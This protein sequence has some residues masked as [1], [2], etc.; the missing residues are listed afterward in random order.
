MPMRDLLP[1]EVFKA[2]LM[3]VGISRTDLQDAVNQANGEFT[4][5]DRATLQKIYQLVNK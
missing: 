2:G 5:D 4:A 3:G 1:N